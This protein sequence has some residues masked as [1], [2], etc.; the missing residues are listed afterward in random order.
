MIVN[1]NILIFVDFPSIKG[2]GPERNQDKQFGANSYLNSFYLLNIL[3]YTGLPT[4]D[5]PSET[6]V[7]ILFSPFPCT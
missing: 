2:L 1:D 6:I 3:T 5:E 7:R 4:K